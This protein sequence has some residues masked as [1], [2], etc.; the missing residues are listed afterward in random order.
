MKRILL[1]EDDATLGEILNERLSQGYLVHWMKTERAAVDFLQKETVDLCILDI[2]LPDGSGFE[3]AR[4]LRDRKAPC[5]FLFLTAQSDAETRLQGYE[6]GAAEFI[7]KPFHLKELLLRVEHVLKSRPAQVELMLPEG[8]VSFATLSV[9]RKDGK[10]EY[11]PVKDMEILKL[12]IQEA[13]QPVS[14]DSIANLV[15]GE[16][17]DLSPRT[18]DNSITRIRQVLSDDNERYIRS[19]RGVGYQWVGPK[20]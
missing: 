11:P 17:R 6:M 12:L 3:V 14:R 10:I 18:I 5:A 16:E 15:W 9:H 8:R 2:G 13:P 7:P 1:V 19:V 4:F 20:E